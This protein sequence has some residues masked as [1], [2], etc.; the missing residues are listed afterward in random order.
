MFNVRPTKDWPWLGAGLQDNPPGFRMD[1]NGEVRLLLGP[2][3]GV[4]ARRIVAAACPTSA[5]PTNRTRSIATGVTAI[6]TATGRSTAGAATMVGAGAAYAFP[7]HA[8]A[9]LSADTAA[10]APRQEH[11]RSSAW[12]A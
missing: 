10:L 7:G 12:S 2:R 3:R 9:A 1:K 8:G 6:D 5:S 4:D 11:S